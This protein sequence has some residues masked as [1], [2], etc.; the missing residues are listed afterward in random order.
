MK[1]THNILS[2][3]SPRSIFSLRNIL[4]CHLS[5]LS[6]DLGI[7]ANSCSARSWARTFWF[8]FSLALIFSLSICQ[9]FKV[10][11][12]TIDTKNNSDFR[13]PME[14]QNPKIIQI[15]K[16]YQCFS[17]D[18]RENPV[19]SVLRSFARLAGSRNGRRA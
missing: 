16:R 7:N 4:S 12:H 10:E 17:L 6:S 19:I 14:P 3:M 5:T 9:L 8:F 15:L 2:G 1:R 13:N 18:H 11:I